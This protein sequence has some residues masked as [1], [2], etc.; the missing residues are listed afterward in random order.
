MRDY[1]A[2]FEICVLKAVSSDKA[3]AGSLN[4]VAS[5]RGGEWPSRCSGDREIVLAND[6]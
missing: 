3:T 6:R 5:L 4:L 2:T 1:I